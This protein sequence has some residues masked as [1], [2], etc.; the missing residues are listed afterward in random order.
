MKKHEN[1]VALITGGNSGIGYWIASE[2][3]A[4]GAKVVIPATATVLA[5]GPH[6]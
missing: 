2:L 4:R 1:K 3:I 5:C 6:A